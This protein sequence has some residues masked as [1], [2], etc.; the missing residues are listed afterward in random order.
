M[1]INAKS[2]NDTSNSELKVEDTY[3]SFV[4]GKV[5]FNKRKKSVSED[6]AEKKDIQKQDIKKDV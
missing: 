6:T 1:G 3:I 5:T 2:T 4:N